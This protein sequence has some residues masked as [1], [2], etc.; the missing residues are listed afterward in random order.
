MSPRI[1]GDL[2]SISA[3][4][5]PAPRM[6]TADPKLLPQMSSSGG[7]NHTVTVGVYVRVLIKIALAR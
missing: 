4:V 5:Q 1:M 7:F 6:Y 2:V 3:M